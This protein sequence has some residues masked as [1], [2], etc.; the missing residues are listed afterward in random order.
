LDGVIGFNLAYSSA[1]SS[2]PARVRVL[3]DGFSLTSHAGI[4]LLAGLALLTLVLSRGFWTKSQFQV[5]RFAALLLILEC[6]L[7]SV[8]GKSFE[9]YFELWL[10]PMAVLSAGLIEQ[11]LFVREP[12][13][14]IVPVACCVLALKIALDSDAAIRTNIAKDVYPTRHAVTFLQHAT[15]PNDKVLV[16][17]SRYREVWFRLGRKPISRFFS[18]TPMTHDKELYRR[19]A[20]EVLHSLDVTSPPFIVEIQQPN[21]PCLFAETCDSRTSAPWDDTATQGLKRTIS[22]RYSLVFEDPGPGHISVYR[23]NPTHGKAA[24]LP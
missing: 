20:P 24:G 3:Y 19:L 4:G 15:T 1:G 13:S 5:A 16:W 6:L 23:L 2:L 17:G 10:L 21:L 7:S 14:A 22:H 11:L 8:S 18:T 9:H 12:Y